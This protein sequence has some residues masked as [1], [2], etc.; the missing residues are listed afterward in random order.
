MAKYVDPITFFA[1]D[2]LGM[3]DFLAPNWKHQA[4]SAYFC[5]QYL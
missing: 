4:K 3:Y 1:I 2:V 5:S